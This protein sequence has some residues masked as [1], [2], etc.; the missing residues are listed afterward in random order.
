MTQV[1]GAKESSP[2]LTDGVATRT[3]STLPRTVT[4]LGPVTA[5]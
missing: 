1:P 5:G 3:E 4:P 2:P